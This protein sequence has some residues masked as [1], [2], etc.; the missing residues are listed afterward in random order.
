MD[1]DEPGWMPQDEKQA[2]AYIAKHEFE[3]GGTL[4]PSLL[5]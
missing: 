5:K 3:G 1:I 4:S 2:A